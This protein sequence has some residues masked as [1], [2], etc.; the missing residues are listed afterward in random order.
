MCWNLSQR[1]KSLDYPLP[2]G[3]VSPLTYSPWPKMAVDLDRVRKESAARVTADP[4]FKEI[5]QK[6]QRILERR[7]HSLQRID[8]AALAQLRKEEFAPNTDEVMEHLPGD[9]GPDGKEEKS[10][11]EQLSDDPYVQEALK[12]FPYIQ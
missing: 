7:E 10:L 4:K 11:S 9:Q 3:Q 5:N 8:L 6:S 2:G 1:E 12:I